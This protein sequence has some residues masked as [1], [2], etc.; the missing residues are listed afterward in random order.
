MRFIGRKEELNR[1]KRL[2]NMSNQNNILIYGRRRMD[3]VEFGQMLHAKTSGFIH[4]VT[5]DYLEFTSEVPGK[6]M[7]ILKVYKN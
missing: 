1:I 3:D 2:I 6:F 5:G 7:E 4:P